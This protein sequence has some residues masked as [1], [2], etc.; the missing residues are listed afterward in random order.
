MLKRCKDCGGTVAIVR[1]VD[2]SNNARWVI[3]GHGMQPCKCGSVVKMQ[4]GC[5]HTLA[6]SEMAYDDLIERWNR[7]R[8]MLDDTERNP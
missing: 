2:V 6:A 8:G 3:V 4:S 5:F 7:E 1:S